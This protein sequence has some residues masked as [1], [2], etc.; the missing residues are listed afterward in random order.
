MKTIIS[1]LV[2]AF[3]VHAICLT[4]LTI[5]RLALAVMACTA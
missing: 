1:W 4:L 5:A 2:T 3:I